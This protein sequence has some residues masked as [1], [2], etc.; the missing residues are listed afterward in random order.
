MGI[1][2]LALQVVSK[3]ALRDMRRDAPVA[4]EHPCKSL[5]KRKQ[6]LFQRLQI[7]GCRRR[8]G[9]LQDC[10]SLNQPSRSCLS[11]LNTIPH[12][13]LFQSVPGLQKFLFV[14]F[15]HPRLLSRAGENAV[16]ARFRLDQRHHASTSRVG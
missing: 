16:F 13:G 7:H 11:L 8:K 12:L 1:P 9:F 4:P 2:P 6:F 10:S 14:F 5:K 3:C 15:L